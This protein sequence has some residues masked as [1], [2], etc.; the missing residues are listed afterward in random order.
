M[1]RDGA[2]ISGYVSE[3]FVTPAALL[4]LQP[5]ESA[6]LRALLPA[7]ATANWQIRFVSENEGVA[8]VD[9]EG[10]VYAQGAGRTTLYGYTAAGGF[11]EFTVLVRGENAEESGEA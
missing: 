6:S 2:W 4:V 9:A 3:R 11:C 7:S 1:Q 10:A 5:G 8:T